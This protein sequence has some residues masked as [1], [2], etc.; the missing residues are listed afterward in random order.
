LLPHGP[1]DSTRGPISQTQILKTLRRTA[2]NIAPKMMSVMVNKSTNSMTAWPRR[3]FAAP[4][5]G[6]FEQ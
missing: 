3:G 1:G 2:A 5:L 6:R 4:A